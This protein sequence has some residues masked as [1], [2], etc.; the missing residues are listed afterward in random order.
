M[1]DDFMAIY[2]WRLQDQ[3]LFLKRTERLFLMNIMASYPRERCVVKTSPS[4]AGGN[5]FDPWSGS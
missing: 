4:N 3:L 2:F 1:K 5:R